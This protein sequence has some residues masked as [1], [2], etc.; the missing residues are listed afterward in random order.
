MYW[1]LNVQVY[2]SYVCTVK[3][4]GKRGTTEQSPLHCRKSPEEY[5]FS[6]GYFRAIS[7]RYY[8]K[9]LGKMFSVIL[10]DTFPKVT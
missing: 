9:Y 1:S 5:F 6:L 7:W 4:G 2:L 10:V 8:N 3:C